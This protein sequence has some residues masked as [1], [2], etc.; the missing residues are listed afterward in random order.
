MGCGSA[1]FHEPIS[2]GKSG[3]PLDLG[4]IAKEFPVRAPCLPGDVLV[5]GDLPEKMVGQLADHCKGWLYVNPESDPHFMP[6]TIKSKGSKVEVLPF[7]PS[8]DLSSSL[9][10]QL[11]KTIAEMSA[12]TH[13][14]VQ[15]C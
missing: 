4:E 7:K 15:R 12:V 8:K 14:A 6:E 9:V 1:K 13:P 10:D 11:V 2:T 3:N 5:S